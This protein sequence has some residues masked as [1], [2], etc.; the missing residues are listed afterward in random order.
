MLWRFA[1]RTGIRKVEMYPN[2]SRCAQVTTV[3]GFYNGSAPAGNALGFADGPVAT[4]K[5]HYIHGVAIRPLDAA[6]AAEASS[7]SSSSSSGGSTELFA[8]EDFNK[9]VR[10]VDQTTNTG[11]TLAGK[12]GSGCADGNG[13]E[14]TF[15]P[16][17]LGVGRD[18]TV[19]VA[20]YSNHRIRAISA[21]TDSSD[22]E[23]GQ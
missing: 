1:H 10:R 19:Y 9:R 4:A 8:I 3:A 12:G 7:S 23:K 14:A 2:G 13:A 15:A 16:V 21:A 6:E 11:T 5:F 20:D 18:G 22:G 17:G